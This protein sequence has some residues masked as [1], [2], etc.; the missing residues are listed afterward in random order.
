MA[1]RYFLVS[2][3]ASVLAAST[4]G[5]SVE[6]FA[7]SFAAS[8]APGV[9]AGADVI[10]AAGAAAGLG[11]SLLQPASPSATKATTSMARFIV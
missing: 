4:L 5:A 1:L 8:A 9:V 10:G 11:C 2:L 3:L 7:V 6:V